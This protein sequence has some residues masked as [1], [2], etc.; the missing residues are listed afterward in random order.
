VVPGIFADPNIDHRWPARFSGSLTNSLTSTLAHAGH[1][2]NHLESIDSRFLRLLTILE[3]DCGQL[4]L[5]HPLHVLADLE[6]S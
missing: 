2:L 6:C 4:E 5:L 1:L 3:S